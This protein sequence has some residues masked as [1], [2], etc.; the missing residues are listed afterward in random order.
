MASRTGARILVD[1]LLI[2]GVNHAFCVP[3]ESYIAV[4]D[5][6]YGAREM[7]K[8]IVTRHESGATFMADAYAKLTGQP[9]VAFVTRGPGATNASIGIHTAIRTSP[10]ILSSARSAASSRNARHSRR[11]ITGACSAR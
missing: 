4:L 9:G 3:G 6:L 8:L 7:I 2:Q 11:S 10:V 1:Q 5:A